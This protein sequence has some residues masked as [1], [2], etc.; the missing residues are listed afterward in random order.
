MTLFWLLSEDV[1]GCIM[2]KLDVLSPLHIS[3]YPP[4]ICRLFSRSNRPGKPEIVG[5][6]SR[7]AFTGRFDDVCWEALEAQASA[8]REGKVQPETDRVC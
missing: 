8:A 4:A 2:H 7:S 6:N 1:G 3:G 5:M